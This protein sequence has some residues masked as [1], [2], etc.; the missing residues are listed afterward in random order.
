LSTNY[1]QNL[2]SF[3]NPNGNDHLDNPLVLHSEQHSNTNDAIEAIENWI[4]ISGSN[5]PYTIE[6]RI[7]NTASGHNH[8]G[9][10]SAPVSL[11]PPESGSQYPIGYFTNFNS[12]TRVG[13]AVDQINRALLNVTSGSSTIFQF[14][15]I[16]L[17]I[18]GVINTVNISAS[19]ETVVASYSGSTATYY[20]S[21]SLKE[22]TRKL[23]I[24]ANGGPFEG[25][26]TGAFR[27]IGYE[28]KVFPTESIWYTDS[29]MNSK[30]VSEK[31]IYN[32]RKLI[33]S[34]EYRAYATD[35]TTVLSTIIDNIYYNGIFESSRSRN[36]T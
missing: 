3:T 23:I 6:F 28:N 4:G 15:G 33:S 24:L 32:S 2:D 22:T 31:V 11:G 20:F 17:G 21:E 7:H 18:S 5:T 1:P 27:V 12:T 16:T 19:S 30:I 29:S 36:I 9:F 8:D 13:S 10:N 14:N 26:A 25:Y 35:G 34:K